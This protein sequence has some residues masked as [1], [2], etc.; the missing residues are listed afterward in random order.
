MN[1]TQKM[2]QLSPISYLIG[3]SHCLFGLSTINKSDRQSISD[4]DVLCFSRATLHFKENVDFI[5]VI[6][7]IKS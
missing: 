3:G 6:D 7:A 2:L 4:S 1:S 5:E